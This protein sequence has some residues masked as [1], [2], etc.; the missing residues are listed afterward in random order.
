MNP[1]LIVF[2]P[3]IWLTFPWRHNVNL[4][5]GITESLS[6]RFITRQ[7][8]HNQITKI[9]KDA[10]LSRQ[11]CNNDVALAIRLLQ[12]TAT[13]LLF[14]PFGQVD[15]KESTKNL[16]VQY[17]EKGYVMRKRFHGL[18]VQKSE[19]WKWNLSEI[20]IK[21]KGAKPYWT[22][23]FYIFIAS[24]HLTHLDKYYLVSSNLTLYHNIHISNVVTW[25][26]YTC[27]FNLDA[28]VFLCGCSRWEMMIWCSWFSLHASDTV[29]FN[30]LRPRQNSRNFADDTFNRIFV[31]ENVRISI[32]FSLS[33]RVQLTIFQHWFR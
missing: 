7:V 19:Q 1:Q 8:W 11:C 13:E 29:D 5:P 16:A 4:T 12:S 21:R 28:L 33:L 24:S 3:V 26:S 22:I 27:L 2:G 6:K 32:K 31:N 30:T 23:V 9:K 25:F 14:E 10:W 20:C 15:N 18:S 17:L